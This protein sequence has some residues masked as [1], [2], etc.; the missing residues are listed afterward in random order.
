MS[1]AAGLAPY[2]GGG[3]RRATALNV[4]ARGGGGGFGGRELAAELA[5]AAWAGSAIIEM[6]VAPEP[7]AAG[8]QDRVID[9]AAPRLPCAAP[10]LPRTRDHASTNTTA[11]ATSTAPGRAK[12]HQDSRSSLDRLPE[13]RQR[14]GFA[15]FGR[16]V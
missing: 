12:R 7:G 15:A 2:A 1:P 16:P 8:G 11:S 5:D 13:P 4:A 14:L 3:S 9:V 10:S 6:R